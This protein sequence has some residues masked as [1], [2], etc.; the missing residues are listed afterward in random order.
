MTY[1]REVA[2]GPLKIVFIMSN[3]GGNIYVICRRR[4]EPCAEIP[5][6]ELSLQER[7]HLFRNLRIR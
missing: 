1:F 7:C 5:S 2:R 6:F 4:S 3:S